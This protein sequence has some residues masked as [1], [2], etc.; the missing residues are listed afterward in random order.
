MRLDEQALDEF[1]DEFEHDAFRQETLTAYDVASDGGDFDFWLAGKPGPSP[2]VVGPWG[3]WIGIQCKRG[4]S[5]RR[6]RVLHDEPSDYLRFEIDWIYHANAEAGERIKILD[7]TERPR[8]PGFIDREFWML[9]GLRAVLMAYDEHGRFLHGD[10]V[11]GEAA[12]VIRQARDA[13][14]EAA[15]PLTSW[16]DRHP[17]YHRD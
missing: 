2:D 16:W 8:P 13:A 5:V 10:T 6:V 15:E 12:E 3:N 17:E 14:W 7:L 9:D 1:T 4:A 11:E